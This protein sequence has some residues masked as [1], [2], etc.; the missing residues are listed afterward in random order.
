LLALSGALWASGTRVGEGTYGA[1]LDRVDVEVVNVDVVVT[2]ARREPVLDLVAGD[3][4]LLVDGKP[5]EVTYF[6]APAPS[7]AAPPAASADATA[8]SPP[9]G[10]G[11]RPPTSRQRRPRP[12]RSS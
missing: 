9:G 6:S 4:E 5:V 2:N 3:F 8:S 7:P 1:F 11:S 10:A 12:R